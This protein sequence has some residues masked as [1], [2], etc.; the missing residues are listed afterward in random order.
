MNRI[1]V[2]T[3]KVIAYL[4]GMLTHIKV[5]LRSNLNS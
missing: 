4:N 1:I 5:K 3:Y 2:I